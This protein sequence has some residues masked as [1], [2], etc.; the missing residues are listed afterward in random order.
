M[1]LLLVLAAGH[2]Y[3]CLLCLLSP[4]LSVVASRQF[5]LPWVWRNV[6][7]V[8]YAAHFSLLV[9]KTA[10]RLRFNAGRF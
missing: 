8:C 4:L 6:I 9:N 7:P 10:V 5:E 1:R 3:H 2:L